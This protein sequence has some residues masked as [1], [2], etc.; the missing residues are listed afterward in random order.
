MDKKKLIGTI[1]GVIFFVVLIAG[2]TFA[3]LTFN[4]TVTN[5]NYNTKTG[6][7]L[8]NYTKGENITDV[9]ITTVASASAVTTSDAQ[10]VIVKAGKNATTAP[11]GNLTIKL[12]TDTT[13][14][15]LDLT[16]GALKYA[17]SIAGVAPTEIKSVTTTDDLTLVDSYTL[18]ST[19][20][21]E[22]TVYFWLDSSTITSTDMGKTY[23][24]YIDAS[25][26]QVE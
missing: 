6:N 26:I 22:F 19:T 23:S 9:P 25:A 15:S 2:A 10:T 14:T 24:G 13:N 11:N 3:W 5:G 1:I 12:K 17:V 16:T 4:A 7:F 8:I 20:Q 21:V 18:T